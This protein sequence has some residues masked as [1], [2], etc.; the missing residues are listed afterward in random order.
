M[1]SVEQT[2]PGGEQ[3]VF[4]SDN[5]AIEFLRQLCNKKNKVIQVSYFSTKNWYVSCAPLRHEKATCFEY[6][7]CVTGIHAMAIYHKGC[8]W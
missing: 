8:W 1:F 3:D 6:L 2:V 5:H 4:C 7:L